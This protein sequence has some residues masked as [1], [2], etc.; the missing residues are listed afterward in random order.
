MQA[1]K[2]LVLSQNARRS[3]WMPAVQI[4]IS[5]MHHDFK[6]HC[7]VTYIDTLCG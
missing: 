4:F 5:Q 3:K 6:R 1:N 7:D 2:T